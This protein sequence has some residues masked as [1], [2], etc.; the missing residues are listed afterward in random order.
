VIDHAAIGEPAN[1]RWGGAANYIDLA[2][3]TGERQDSSSRNATQ[4]QALQKLAGRVLQS[5]D[6]EEILL[7]VSH[8][9]KRLLASDIC[10]V[11]MRVG[12]EVVVRNC[13]GHF[14]AELAGGGADCLE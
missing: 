12:D 6:I 3:A 4:M 8:E 11:L 10:G 14:S 13:V 2:I 1:R 7:L 9:T 5:S